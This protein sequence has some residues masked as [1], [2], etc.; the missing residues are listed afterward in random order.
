MKFNNFK[1]SQKY[2]FYP[3]WVHVDQVHG[4]GKYLV[5]SFHGFP[6]QRCLVSTL[7]LLPG[8]LG[9]HLVLDQVADKE[10]V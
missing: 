1:S 3:N 10:E 7:S 4:S 8:D 5:K 2:K 6:H 9:T